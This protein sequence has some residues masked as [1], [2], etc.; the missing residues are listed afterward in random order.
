MARGAAVFQVAALWLLAVLGA[1]LLLAFGPVV[2][3]FAVPVVF[4]AMAA[5]AGPVRALVA[6]AAFVALAFLFER[7]FHH[8]AVLL[9]SVILGV[10]AVGAWMALQV[11]PSLFRKRAPGNGERRG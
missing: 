10:V 8:P 2:L 11:V 3:L 6:C 5:A 9:L 1:R 7:V 4:V